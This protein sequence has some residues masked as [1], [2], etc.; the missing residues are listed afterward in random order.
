[1]LL[2]IDIGNT[3]FKWRLQASVADSKMI[4]HGSLITAQLTVEQLQE[5]LPAGVE[6]CGFT[7]VADA[8][9]N[10]LVLLWAQGQGIAV[11][12]ALTQ[13]QWQD[14]RNSYS[15]CSRMGVDRWLAMVAVRSLTKQA[16]CVIDCGSAS[17]VDFIAA[18]G[19]HEGGYII[20]GQRLMVQ[21][22]LKDTANIAF[23]EHERE[24]VAGYGTSTAGAVLKGAGRMHEAGIGA[25]ASEALQHGYVVYATGGDGE[26]LSK[27]QGIR[28]LDELVLDGLK[29][30]LYDVPGLLPH[31]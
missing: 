4:A 1:M 16:A 29:A 8:K 22:L 26:F 31:Q 6:M 15:D 10:D 24:D 25:I 14:L 12:Q 7:S 30:C 28:F 17:T 27:I 18:D 23:A 9:V 5:Q 20:P 3:R 11:K 21:S 13:P 19:Q 2:L